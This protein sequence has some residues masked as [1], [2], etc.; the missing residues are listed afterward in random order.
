MKFIGFYPNIPNGE[1]LVSIRKFL[2]TRY[3]KEISADALVELAEVVLKISIFEFDETTFKQKRG[4]E[5]ETKFSPPYAILFITDFEEKMLTS[6]EKTPMIWWRYIDN[7]FFICEY[8][9]ESL[10]IFI[11]QVKMFHSTIKF[12]AKYSEEEVK[13]LD[14]NIKVLDGELKKD[15]FVKPTSTHQLLDST[16]CYP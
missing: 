16:S 15:L 10:E 4:T 2:K 13:F 5:I 1:D 11:E 14:V 12:A 8:D 9:E 6:F 3:S 7:I